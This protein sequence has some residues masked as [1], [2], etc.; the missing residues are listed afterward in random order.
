VEIAI[1]TNRYRDFCDNNPEAVGVFRIAERIFLPFVVL[2]G[3]RAGFA[4]GS[5]GREN[6]KTLNL[7]LGRPR[8]SLL[9]ADEETTFQYA[10]LFYQLREQGTPIPMH[11]IWIAALAVQHDLSL[12]TRDEHFSNLPQLPRM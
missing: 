10:R 11:D 7:F 8:V 9:F 6:E 12:F 5:R 2:A 1:D 3:L 4:A